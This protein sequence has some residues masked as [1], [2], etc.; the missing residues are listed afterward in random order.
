MELSN[1]MRPDEKKH[2][3]PTSLGEEVQSDIHDVLR[4]EV[5]ACQSLGGRIIGPIN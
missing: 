2:A 3:V 4:V 5:A 1:G